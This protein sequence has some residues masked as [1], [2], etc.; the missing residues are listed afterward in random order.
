MKSFAAVLLA[1]GRSARMRTNKALL[2]HKGMP[3]WRLQMGKLAQLHPDQ[4]FFSI[5]PAMKFPSGPWTFIHDRSPD[6]G[7]LGGLE[8]ALRLTRSDSLIALA[9][10]MPSMTVEFLSD[11]LDESG[12]TGVAPRV[13]GFYC[14]T[15]AV[16][17]V[18]ILPL[19]ERIL[20]GG[21]RS[22][23]RLI[24]EALESGLMKAKEIPSARRS[25]FENWNTPDDPRRDESVSSR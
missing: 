19:V 13:D 16:Y 18:K 20:A 23:Q 3:L 10:D 15:A 21:D 4:L 17:P 11:L 22:F 12:P 25:L 8:A 7:P 9:I 14:G 2:S 6:L 5:R 1:G 24:S